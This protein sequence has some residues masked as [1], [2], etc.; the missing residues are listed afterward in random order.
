MPYTGCEWTFAGKVCD[1]QKFERSTVPRV[2]EE[3]GHEGRGW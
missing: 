3:L 2:G 1:E